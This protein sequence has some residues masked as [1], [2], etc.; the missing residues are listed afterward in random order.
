LH[1]A[2][3]A[4]QG[5][6]YLHSGCNPSV[7]HRDVKTNNILL[8]SD[9][10]NAK[11]A[12]FGVSTLMYGE[13]VTHVTTNVKGTIGY[14]DPEYF[15]SQRLS[16]KSDVYSFGVVLLEIIS[17]RKAIDTMSPNREAWNICDW[18]QINLQEGNINEILDP[19]VKASNPNV[20]AL[21]K[22]AKIAIECVEPKAIDRPIM[23]KV[24]E[25]LRT[26]INLQEDNA[27]PSNYS[28][29]MTCEIQD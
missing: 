10:K 6:E 9:M 18:V 21:W 20:D 16:V 28:H 24:V 3:N 2:L 29:N 27:L 19:I 22:V 13:N 15:T 11:V 8:P 7:I 23:T 5:L 17:G 1:I 14:L 26:A 25:E 4:S 12:D